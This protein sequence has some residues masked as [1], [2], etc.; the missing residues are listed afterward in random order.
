M[1]TV[2]TEWISIWIFSYTHTFKLKITSFVFSFFSVNNFF[3][4]TLIHF[5]FYLPSDHIQISLQNVLLRKFVA[6]SIDAELF[7]DLVLTAVRAFWSFCYDFD[8][9]RNQANCRM[10]HFLICLSTSF[11]GSVYLAPCIYCKLKVIFRDFPGEPVV[12]NP[13]ANAGDT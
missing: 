12:K 1:T 9:E 2:N 13:P 5:H 3:L 4:S 10:F 11:C 7:I 8:F 6:S